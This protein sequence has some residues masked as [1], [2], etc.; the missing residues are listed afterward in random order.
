MTKVLK[1][2]GEDQEQNSI[3]SPCLDFSLR[4]AI[5]R[6][7][8]QN[9]LRTQKNIFLLI[10]MPGNIGDHL[11]WAGTEDLLKQGNISYS[12]ISVNEISTAHFPFNTLVI[13]GSGAFSHA[14]HEWLPDLI[15]RASDHFEKVIVLPSTFH[16][17]IPI[18][19]QCLSAH[20]VFPF[21]REARSY[22]AIKNT[23][24]AALSFD[25]ALYY[26]KFDEPAPRASKDLLLS[27]RIDKDSN[28]AHLNFK[29]NPELNSDIS[30]CTAS[31]DEW[32]KAIAQAST[33]V[34]DRLH[35]AVASVMLKKKV[36]YYDTVSQKITNYFNYVFRESLNES[37]YKCSADWLFTQGYVVKNDQ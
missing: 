4:R 29:P 17:D 16:M 28:L 34:T 7:D 12:P 19:A 22:S 20:N 10:E 33:I 14:Y 2:T 6:E 15:L 24:K 23:K 27:L 37:I 30:S 21:A 13:P 31:L 35:I 3:L 8:L 32:F 25:C 9:F 1:K 36:Y 18:V 11:I 5:Y 26:H